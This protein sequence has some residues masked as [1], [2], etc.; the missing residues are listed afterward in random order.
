MCIR[1][2][3]GPCTIDSSVHPFRIKDHNTTHAKGFT[4]DNYFEEMPDAF[5]QDN[6]T[7]IDYTNTGN[8]MSTSR[9]H[10]ELQN[11]IDCGEFSIRTQKAIDAYASCLKYS[12][13]SLIR[14]NVDKRI[15]DN[16]R[17]KEGKLIDSQSEVGGWDPYLV[18]KRPNRWDTDRDGM[19]DN[20]EKANGL[21]PSDPSDATSDSDN[22]G[23]TNIEGYIN[24]LCSAPLL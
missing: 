10:W 6:F 3:P 19:P 5:N 13:C 12:G 18:E 2:R 15:I 11:E 1:D 24:S 16:I 8:Y 7:A 22:D 17:A 21:D 4:K 23:Y 20:W 9:E 14:D